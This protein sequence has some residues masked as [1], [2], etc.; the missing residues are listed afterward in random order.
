MRVIEYEYLIIGQLYFI[1]FRIE[2]KHIIFLL[3]KIPYRENH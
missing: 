2:K 1:Q 3:F